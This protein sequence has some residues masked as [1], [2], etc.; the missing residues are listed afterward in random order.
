MRDLVAVTLRV[1]RFSVAKFVKPA[2][3]S[4]YTSSI[5]VVEDDIVGS[6]F[7]HVLRLGVDLG[8]W[9]ALDVAHRVHYFPPCCAIICRFDP[10]GTE[11][12]IFEA[13]LS[14]LLQDLRYARYQLVQPGPG[15]QLLPT[16]CP[17]PPHSRK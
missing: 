11:D 14:L 15:C 4:G 8:D 7:Q 13:M 12:F 5:I 1:Y 2:D 3:L 9:V 6:L 10:P 16:G 17:C